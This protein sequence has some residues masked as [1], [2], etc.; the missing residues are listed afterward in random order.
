MILVGNGS[1]I[2][3]AIPNLRS[4]D[5][6][7]IFLNKENQGELKVT[8]YYYKYL[9]FQ[10]HCKQLEYVI[11]VKSDTKSNPSY[12]Y[13]DKLFLKDREF[14]NRWVGQSLMK[15]VDTELFQRRKDIKEVGEEKNDLDM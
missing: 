6:D 12:K 1:L 2:K 5:Q 14:D 15:P 9:K 11:P 10:I 13:S 8:C 3:L 4:K 7:W